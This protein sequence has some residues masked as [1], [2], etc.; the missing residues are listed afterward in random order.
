LADVHNETLARFKTFGGNRIYAKFEPTYYF[1]VDPTM[2]KSNMTFIDEVNGLRAEKFITEEFAD[3]IEGAHPLHCIHK[4][5]FSARPFEYVYA[6]FSVITVM[7]QFAFAMGFER[8]GLVGM[9]HHYSEPLGK[10]AWHPASADTNH[11]MPNYY[12]SYLPIW[13]AP[14]LD[15]LEKWLRLA[16]TVYKADG[17]LIENLTPGSKLKIFPTGKLE[18]WLD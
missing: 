17:R 12:D 1:F 2:A 7:L 8:V 3:K 13:K 15:L 10:R 14:R 6:Y 5:G 18:D 11:F 9:D 16:K 4:V